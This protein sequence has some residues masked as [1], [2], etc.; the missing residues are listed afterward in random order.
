MDTQGWI[1][2]PVGLKSQESG[3]IRYKNYI[4]LEANPNGNNA[5]AK[6]ESKTVGF[7]RENVCWIPDLTSSNRFDFEV[8]GNPHPIRRDLYL[9]KIPDY[10]VG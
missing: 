8:D 10:L 2:D 5:S 6:G 4:G 7:L 1:F 9:E 3:F